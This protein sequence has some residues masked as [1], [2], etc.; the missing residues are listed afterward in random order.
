MISD[1]DAVM[2][3]AESMIAAHKF[4]GIPQ[5]IEPEDFISNLIGQIL[6]LYSN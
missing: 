5:L 1:S 4:L 3:V 2:K 6:L